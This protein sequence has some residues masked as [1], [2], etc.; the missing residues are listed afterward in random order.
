MPLDSQA[1]S[2][3]TGFST[4]LCR[5]PMK[6]IINSDH[7]KHADSQPTSVERRP[8]KVTL[9]DCSAFFH[10]PTKNIYIVTSLLYFF[11]SVDSF[12]VLAIAI[13]ADL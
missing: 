5:K 1:T 11:P 2:V 9:S 7:V 10:R 3:L 13:S 6:L 4:M 12:W 8:I